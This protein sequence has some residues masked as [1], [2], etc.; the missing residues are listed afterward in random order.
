[1]ILIPPWMQATM[2]HVKKSFTPPVKSGGMKIKEE[3]GEE[4]AK[5]LAKILVDANIV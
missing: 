1:M 5:K 2:T 3:T 4:S